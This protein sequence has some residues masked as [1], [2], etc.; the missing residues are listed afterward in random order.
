MLLNVSPALAAALTGVEREKAGILPPF[1]TR[2]ELDDLLAAWHR[3]FNDPDCKIDAL[4]PRFIIH[5]KIFRQPEFARLATHPVVQEAVRRTIGDF[6]LANW[7]VVA[8]PRNGDS[9]TPF[10]Q[11]PFHIDHVVYSDTPVEDA[12][13]T[14]VCVWVNFEELRPENGPFAVA[15]GSHKFN[16]GYEF[17]KKRPGLRLVDLG[18]VEKL[19]HLNIGPPGTTAVYSGKTW[20]SATTNCSQ[21]MRKGLNMNFVPRQPLDTL[22]RNPFDACSLNEADYAEL[23][24]LLGR[25]DYV[26]PRKMA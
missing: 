24:R 4:N 10:D 22:R 19:T 23:V 11:I 6:Q 20:H 5:P 13:D 9:I 8:T 15:V 18:N 17:F 2:A 1:L 25:A 12:R 14:F 7:A 21:V 26:I 3:I 16:I